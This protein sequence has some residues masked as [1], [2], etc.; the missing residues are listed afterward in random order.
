MTLVPEIAIR[1]FLFL[2]FESRS[3][4]RKGEASKASHGSEGKELSNF[5]RLPNG[6]GEE[7]RQRNYLSDSSPRVNSRDSILF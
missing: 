5:S 4:Q 6:C 7:S 1:L 2:Y 3:F